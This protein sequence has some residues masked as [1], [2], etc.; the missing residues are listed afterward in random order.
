MSWLTT[1]E[2]GS[3]IRKF[4]DEKTK[5]AFMGIF[6]IDKLPRRITKLP[7]LLIINTHTKNLPGEHWK[8]I[9]ISSQRRG[10]VFDSFAL[11]ISL[12]L[13]KWINTFTHG[14]WKQNSRSIQHPSSTICGIYVLYYVLNRLKTDDLKSIMDTFGE[15]K[16]ENDRLMMK[17]FSPFRNKK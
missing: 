4:G 17:F 1:E 9:Y 7:A 2:I 5:T 6:P 16:T 3:I 12:Y 14:R 11:P 10:E 15:S 13:Q 8:A